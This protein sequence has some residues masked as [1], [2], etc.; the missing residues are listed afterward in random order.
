MVNHL[1]NGP[2]TANC[3][4]SG[5]DCSVV[6]VAP[7]FLWISRWSLSLT[8]LVVP[9]THAVILLVQILNHTHLGSKLL[10]CWL[11]VLEFPMNGAHFNDAPVP[12]QS[13]HGNET[14]GAMPQR[15]TVRSQ[16]PRGVSI[17]P[18]NMEPLGAMNR[19]CR[20][21]IP[22]MIHGS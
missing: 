3:Q 10:D 12:L 13:Q 17:S 7:K 6:I 1:I 20:Y 4:I 21:G 18:L 19:S 5:I 14:V 11:P 15:A 2:S 22:V 8:A 16:G 9:K